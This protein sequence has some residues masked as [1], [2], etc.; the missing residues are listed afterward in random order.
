[1]PGSSG[2]RIEELLSESAYPHAVTR[3]ALKQTHLSWVVL[4]GSFAYKLKKPVR[5][6]FVDASALERRR[7]LCQEEL[8]LNRRFAPELYLDVV[9]I[10]REAGRLKVGGSSEPLEYAVRM[11]EFA[12][13][14]ELGSRLE[15]DAVTPQDIAA[16]GGL[17]ADKHESAEPAS[18]DG[19]FGTLPTVWQPM[20][21]NFSLLRV[22]LGNPQQ[23]QQLAR[24]ETR[25]MYR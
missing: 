2:L 16:L 19:P 25:S 7:H 8:R 22:R 14:Q 1:M 18:V 3:L 10:T 13:A 4:T 5:F 17:L 11:R 20:L 15:R 9:P 6:D 24:L 12:E 23:R 21:D